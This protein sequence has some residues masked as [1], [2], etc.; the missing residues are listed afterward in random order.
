VKGWGSF[1]RAPGAADHAVQV[2]DDRAELERI[3]SAFVA[4]GFEAGAPAVVIARDEHRQAFEHRLEAAG[5]PLVDGGLFVT[6]DAEQTLATFMRGDAP[7][8]EAFERVVGGL[9]D[10][11]AARFP[12]TRIRAFGEMVDLLWQRGQKAAAIAL[13]RMWNE[14]AATRNFAL[15]CAYRLDVLDA[16]VQARALPEIFAAHTH[17]RPV[18]EPAVFN[19]AVDQALTEIVG[20]VETARIYLA[21]AEQVPQC[22]LPRAQ[23]VL[24]WLSA[25]RSVVARQV[26]E[27]LRVLRLQVASA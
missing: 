2:Y 12:G 25:N 4:A 24:T 5:W 9:L 3:V 23:A 16:D 6:A 27:R 19:A 10:E 14:L 13:E 17:A 18:A 26:L 7:D 15:L 1:I 11:T 8:A 22:E 20:P 21:V